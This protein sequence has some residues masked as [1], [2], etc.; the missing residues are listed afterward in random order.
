MKKNIK[1]FS[2]SVRRTTILYRI[3]KKNYV[4]EIS[5]DINPDL[6]TSKIDENQFKEVF[7]I[8]PK[9]NLTPNSL[10]EYDRREVN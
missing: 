5:E 10:F 7:G 8:D 9:E 1:I 6:T 3:G 4:R 2:S